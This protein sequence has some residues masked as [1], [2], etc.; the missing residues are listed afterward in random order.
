MNLEEMKSLPP[1][2]QEALFKKI[3]AARALGKT[4]NY[5][6]VYGVSGETL[7][8]QGG[9]S[10]K[11][12]RTLLE[13]Y[14]IKNWGVKQIAEEQVVFDFEYKV[15]ATS[16]TLNQ[17]WLINPINGFCYEC[18]KD[19]DRFSTLCQGTGSFFFDCWVSNVR[20][21]LKEE[22]HE[23]AHCFSA[24]DE[25]VARLLEENKEFYTKVVDEALERVNEKYGLRRKLGCDICFGKTYAEIH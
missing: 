20:T 2:E 14:W 6:A 15:P 11:E 22:G 24:H 13:G 21:L 18:R 9:M 17:R 8:M 23:M 4:T 16:E 1:E 19:A 10:V 25:F 3:H 12:A 7:S 5:A